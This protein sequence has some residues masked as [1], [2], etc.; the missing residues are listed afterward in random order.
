MRGSR[1]FAVVTSC[2]L[3]SCHTDAVDELPVQ[4]TA[5]L[6]PIGLSSPDAWA[7]FDRSVSSTFKPTS[8]SVGVA[9]DRAQTIAAVKVFGPSPYRLS[10]SGPV[11]LGFEANPWH[12][13]LGFLSSP[14]TCLQKALRFI[15]KNEGI[16]FGMRRP[17]SPICQDTH[18]LNC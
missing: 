18:H 2:L 8:R 11:A 9:F 1:F 13:E 16:G 6:S 4:G 12:R 3:A 7:L 17:T 15:L 14:P 5:R 10:V